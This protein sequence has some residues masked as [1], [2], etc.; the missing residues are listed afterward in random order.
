ME[1][2]FDYS[3]MI[4]MKIYDCIVIGGGA[5]GLFFAS[6]TNLGTRNGLILEATPRIGMKLI[7]SGGGHCNITH[8]GAIKDF[9]PRYGES[10]KAI[11]KIL[12]R[13]SNLELIEFL[14]SNGVPC[15]AEEDGRVFPK[16]KKAMDVRAMLVRKAKENGFDIKTRSKVS[17]ISKTPD[18]MWNICGEYMA[19]NIVI[20]TGGCSYPKT[21]SD[22][23]MFDVLRRDL[24]LEIA[25]LRPA[26]APLEIIDHPYS[27]IAGLSFDVRVKYG[28]KSS[29]G[30]L[31]FTHK[32][33]SGPAIINISG[34]IKIGDEIT[35]NYLPASNFEEVFRTLQDAAQGSKANLGILIAK[36]FSLP[37]SFSQI[38]AS[39]SENS[40]KKAAR[41]LTE[42]KLTVSD[43]GSFSNAMVTRGGVALSEVDLTGMELKRHRGAFV[44]GEALDVDG[45]SGG[46]NLQFAYSSASVAS[47][48]ILA[49]L[50]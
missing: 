34:D 23:S 12:Y 42:N 25:P 32:G 31:L 11:R 48:R 9:V 1:T 8:A 5:S 41:I 26:L 14:E 33:L 4:Y 35:I 43:T 2:S 29:R 46:Y 30:P 19:R 50:E 27:E 7:M 47:E 45:I 36:A 44:I 16:S 21:G 17:T 20:A 10:G 28:K 49:S 13:H 40:T 3:R 15:E 38:V 24:E 6:K 18:G 22:G 37:K 39:Q